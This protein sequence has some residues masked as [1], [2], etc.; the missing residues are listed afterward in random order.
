MSIE[1]KNENI[2]TGGADLSPL[3]SEIERIS[4]SNNLLVSGWAENKKKLDE[5]NEKLVDYDKHFDG[6]EGKSKEYDEKIKNSEFRSIELIGII[7]S[8]I[9]LV[10]VYTS[11]SSN[12]KDLKSSY[13]ILTL[14]S[15]TLILFA[16]LMHAF[17]NKDDKRGAWYNILA[18]LLPI[19][20]ILATG[21]YILFF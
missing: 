2:E 12:Q 1:N 8:I 16:T 4:N 10:L 7:S 15:A 21:V 20:I 11:N 9:A 6:L 14:S 13:L 17:F 3:K 5:I 18:I 19:L